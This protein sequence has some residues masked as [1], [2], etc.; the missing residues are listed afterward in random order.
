MAMA[1]RPRKP[2]VVDGGGGGGLP[3]LPVKAILTGVL[4]LLAL[5]WIIQ[6][7]PYYMVAPDEEGVVLTFGR[8]TKTTEPGFH[9][10]WP[11]PVQTVE[12]PKVAEVKRIELGFRSVTEG[13]TTR[14][15]TFTNDPSLLHEARMLTG[16]EN[17]VDCS[18]V[19]QYRIK[20]AIDYLFN[21]RR[22]E[23]EAALRDVSEA[24]LRQAVGDHPIDDVLTT[25]KLEVQNEIKQKMQELADLYG[26]GITVTQLQLQDVQPP[27]EV[28]P[29]FRDVA[30]ARE[31]REQII[32]EARAYQR[33][34]IPRAEG[35]G[36][37]MRLDAQGYK[38]ARI[39]EAQGAVAR[40][41][42]IA[43][44]YRSAPEVTRT[45]LYLEAMSELLPRIKLTVVDPDAGLVTL[46]TLGTSGVK[47]LAPPAAAAQASS[48]GDQP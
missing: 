25:G 12:T 24:A 15:V 31:E 5:V 4:V 7:G 2:E 38:E 27:K 17:V 47:S 10:K 19:V 40:F 11:W 41:S 28:A 8:Y 9:F 1:Y 32:N 46:K 22:D 39:A 26:M 36:E 48:E 29:A 20:D 34:R 21:F 3:S 13:G 6:G 45:R 30:T 43:E 14:Y 23:P 44:Q 18:M 42:A 16:D 35:E 33:E 37:R